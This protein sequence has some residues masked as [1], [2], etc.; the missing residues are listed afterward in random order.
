MQPFPNVEIFQPCQK[1]G[2][3]SAKKPDNNQHKI[4]ERRRLSI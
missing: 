2:T 1:S 4:K 3:K